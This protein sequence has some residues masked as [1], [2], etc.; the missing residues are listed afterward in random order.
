MESL[1]TID[2]IKLLQRQPTPL[3]SLSDFE[4]ILGIENRRTLYKKIQRLED[5]KII[6][7]L[8]KGK[9]RFLLSTVNDFTMA[10][11]LYRPSYISLETALSFYGIITGFPYQITSITIQKARLFDVGGKEFK[12]SRI[13]PALFWGWE[14]K[15]DFLIA[16]KEK[17][18]LDYL[19]FGLKGIRDFDLDEI[20]TTGIDRQ[21]LLSFAS[22]FNS[23][24]L[25]AAAARLKR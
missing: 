15:E 17:A 18:L 6:Q 1:S 3:F 19:Y 9:Y 11:F 16:E 12:F 21:K 7:R 14:K 4:R 13:S 23:K 25:L 8:I 10:N 2:V 20:D 24:H 22:R 5:K